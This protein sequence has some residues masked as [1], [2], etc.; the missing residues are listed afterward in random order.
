[1]VGGASVGFLDDLSHDQARD[2]WRR[3]LSEPDS[4]TW[5]AF[6][7]DERVVGAVRLILATLPNARHR[8]QVAKLLV[9]RDARGLGCATALLTALE[10]TARTLGRHVLV[11][12]TQTGSTAEGLYRRRGW[13]LVGTVDDY[14]AMP[15]GRLAPTTF[16][17]KQL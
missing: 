8:A 4:L 7:A 15:D 17:T 12:D 2:W 9:H 10:E 6:T 5:A 3:A 14:A 13:Q 11:L 16:M 1:V